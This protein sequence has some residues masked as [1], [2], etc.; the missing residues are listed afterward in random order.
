MNL[1]LWIIKKLIKA[2]D[3]TVWEHD[4]IHGTRGQV[5]KYTEFDAVRVMEGKSIGL[6]VVKRK[7]RSVD[8]GVMKI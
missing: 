5:N 3:L 7:F 8:G 6:K 4:N 1:R 2:N